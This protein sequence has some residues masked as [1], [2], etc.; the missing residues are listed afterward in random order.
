MLTTQFCSLSHFLKHPRRSNKTVGDIYRPPTPHPPPNFFSPQ[1]LL[2]LKA[3]YVQEIN[4]FR[5][6]LLQCLMLPGLHLI[7][8]FVSMRKHRTEGA[9]GGRENSNRM[10]YKASKTAGVIS[11]TDFIGGDSPL[12][13][14]SQ[15]S[16]WVKGHGCTFF[17]VSQPEPQGGG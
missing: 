3:R 10:F 14:V 11:A 7:S 16:T 6:L 12:C 8:N 5:H 1:T 4:T 15:V 2:L 13:K 17:S 9:S